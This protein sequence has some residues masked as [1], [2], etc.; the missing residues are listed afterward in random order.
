M[1]DGAPFLDQYYNTNLPFPFPDSLQEFSV[2]T[3]NYSAHYG[4][5]AGGVV[6]VITISGTNSL[7]GALF[8]FNRNQAYNAANAFTQVVD[9]LHRND[10]G[11]TIGGPV[12]IPHL[13]NGRDHKF[14]FFSATKELAT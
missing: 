12:Y 7:Q 10:F 5:N 2:Q 6:N 11:G 13:Y 8:E 14:F 9:S 3:S 1:L 4:G